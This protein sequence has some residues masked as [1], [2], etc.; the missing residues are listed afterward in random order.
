MENSIIMHQ[1]DDVQMTDSPGTVDPRLGHLENNRGNE[2][3][4]GALL[5][6]DL[7]LEIVGHATMEDNNNNPQLNLQLQVGFMRVQDTTAADPVF[8]SL[9]M[10]DRAPSLSADFYRIWG[11]F[12]SPMGDP[13]KQ[14]H[15]PIKWASFFTV[16]LLNQKSFSWAKSFLSSG[17][18]EVM[19][20]NK[21]NDIQFSIPNEC[22]PF[23][24]SCSGKK[25]ALENQPGPTTPDSMG[26]DHQAAS[27][28]SF[29][30]PKKRKQ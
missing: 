28:T 19:S 10:L 11:R 29:V 5:L 6:N 24:L 1:G 23:E 4:E 25:K 15:I 27:S 14:I 16:Q 30:L 21:E 7:M 8:E 2:L 22:P 26:A 17:V 20:M 12:F 18:C 3:G 13:E 9:T